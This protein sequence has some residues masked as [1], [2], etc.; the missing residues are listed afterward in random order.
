MRT[1][2]DLDE[3]LIERAV[4]LTGVKERGALVRM[5]LEGLIARESGRR[6]ARLKGTLPDLIAPERTAGYPESE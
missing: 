4:E 1:K 6:L 5:A 2:I 3:K